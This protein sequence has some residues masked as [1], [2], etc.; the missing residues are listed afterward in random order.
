MS[1]C[2]PPAQPYG[3]LGSSCAHFQPHRR[4]RHRRGPS[5]PQAG[6]RA[7]PPRV[8]GPGGSRHGNDGGGDGIGAGVRAGQCEREPGGRLCQYRRF[9]VNRAGFGLPGELCAAAPG[10][11]SVSP[12]PALPAPPAAGRAPSLPVTRGLYKLHLS[13]NESCFGIHVSLGPSTGWGGTEG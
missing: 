4:N 1:P 7:P 2:I 12:R 5:T 13:I 6:K 3:G 10:G 11:S 9:H 8:P